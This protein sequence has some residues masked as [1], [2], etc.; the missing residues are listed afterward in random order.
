MIV[1]AMAYVDGEA[2]RAAVSVAAE[3]VEEAD[4][5]EVPA[6]EEAEEEVFFVDKSRTELSTVTLSPTFGGVSNL[7]KAHTATWEG[8]A[9]IQDLF[10]PFH[11]PPAA[12]R[13]SRR[14]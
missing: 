1:P 12:F 9:Y 14:E 2:R 6:D 10:P 4:V 3:V 13:I 5:L 8:A 7:N 11:L